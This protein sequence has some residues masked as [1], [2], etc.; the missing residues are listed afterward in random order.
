MASHCTRTRQVSPLG[1]RGFPAGDPNPSGPSPRPR[2]PLT[3]QSF[4]QGPP[5]R[6][7]HTVLSGSLSLTCGGTTRLLGPLTAPSILTRAPPTICLSV[8]PLCPQ[9]PL[10]LTS[11][12]CAACT[13]FFSDKTHWSRGPGRQGLPS[14]RPGP[15]APPLVHLPLGLPCARPHPLLAPTAGL[16]VPR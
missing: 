3:Q 9:Q 6:L 7:C 16:W 2:L 8:R 5:P 4:P 15:S 11:W 1:S 14:P 13:C 12:Q 10:P